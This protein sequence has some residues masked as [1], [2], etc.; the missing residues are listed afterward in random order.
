MIRQL[1]VYY[2][3]S[4]RNTIGALQLLEEIDAVQ[5]G[6]PFWFIMNYKAEILENS[7]KA[8]GENIGFPSSE[9]MDLF[10]DKIRRTSNFKE[11]ELNKIS[12]SFLA[13]IHAGVIP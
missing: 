11:R 2:Q 9:D 13:D 7:F 5:S 12:M 10:I 8:N 1:N 3:D 4:S 6:I